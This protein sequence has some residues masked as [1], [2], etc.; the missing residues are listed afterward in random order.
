[1]STNTGGGYIRPINSCDICETPL[2]T[3]M[4]RQ[5]GVCLQCWTAQKTGLAATDGKERASGGETDP[6]AVSSRISS[7]GGNGKGFALQRNPQ[8]TVTNDDCS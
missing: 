2:I 6:A 7:R 8:R 1:M 3:P 4:S 5:R